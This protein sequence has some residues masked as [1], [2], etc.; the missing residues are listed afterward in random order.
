M[1]NEV[2]NDTFRGITLE[3]LFGLVA[4][5]YPLREDKW[6]NYVTDRV[7]QMHKFGLYSV[8]SILKNLDYLSFNTTL[9]NEYYAQHIKRSERPPFIYEFHAK[10][11]F[12]IARWATHLMQLHVKY[13]MQPVPFYTAPP[14]RKDTA[15]PSPVDE[16]SSPTTGI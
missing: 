9:H 15:D 12:E 8:T 13:Q 4:K 3:T 10:E 7:K 5:H 11:T 2:Q 14:I 6:S 1:Y 16:V